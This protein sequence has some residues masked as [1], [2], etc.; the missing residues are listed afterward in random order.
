MSRSVL[1]LVA[2]PDDEAL[3]FA[4]AIAAA[5]AAGE[6][7]RVAVATNGDAPFAGRALRRG[8]AA[9]GNPAQTLRYGL[10]RTRET[11]AAMR[12]L[13][14]RWHPDA[15]RSEVLFLG[16]RN[17]LLA[18][19]ASSPEPVASDP[20]GLRRTYAGDPRRWR[21]SCRRDLSSQ[22]R[23]RHAALAAADLAA[24][25]D[26]LLAL[27]EPDLVYTHAG[28]DG[29]PDHAALHD[30][31]AAALARSRATVEVRT[32][33]IHPEGTGERMYESAYEWPNPADGGDPEAR[34]RPDLGFEPPPTPTGP[35]WGPLGPPD[36]LLETPSAMRE[37]DPE[38]N[39]KWRAIRCYRS[40]LPAMRDGSGRAHPAHGYLRA[41]VKR[42][43]FFWR[44][45]FVDGV[46]GRRVA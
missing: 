8:G 34:F 39:L 37:R 29:H 46:D 15:R 10:R 41:F 20:T 28:F 43:E 27:A 22:L 11:V 25:V 35:S 38:R 2:H 42:H 12:E 26:A 5:V 4:G 13:G 14:L 3:G 9:S 6:R 33:L 23:G 21:R 18:S 30:V 17:G 16:Y 19:V 32:T 31:V 24:D 40:Q 45:P 44:H 1:V 7:V 36:E